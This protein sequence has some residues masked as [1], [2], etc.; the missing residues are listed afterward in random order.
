MIFDDSLMTTKFPPTHNYT[1]IARLLK[2]RYFVLM[3]ATNTT[4]SVVNIPVCEA[5]MFCVD[6]YAGNYA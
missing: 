1:R 2:T 5:A 3:V 6:T 4:E